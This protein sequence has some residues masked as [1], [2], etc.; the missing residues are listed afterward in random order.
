MDDKVIKSFLAKREDVLRRAIENQIGEFKPSELKGRLRKEVMKG[1]EIYYLD[2]I[3]LASFTD[4][5][6]SFDQDRRWMSI[7][8]NGVE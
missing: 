7:I 1:I 5:E 8:N 6:K 4:P 2:G 3:P